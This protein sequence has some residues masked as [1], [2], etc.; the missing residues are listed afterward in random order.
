[1]DITTDLFFCPQTDKASLRAL[2]Q[3]M[4]DTDAKG[5]MILACSDESWTPAHI[6]PIL[7]DFP[8]LPIFG[9]VFPYI[10]Y[11]GKHYSSG[12][13]VVGLNVL[14]HITVIRHIS[15]TTNTTKKQINL[16]GKSI[17]QAKSLIT[18]VDGLAENIESFLEELCTFIAKG[19]KVAGGGAGFL[20]MSKRPCVFTNAGMLADAA[21][22]V[23][24]DAPIQLAAGH[25][26][27]IMKGPFLVT[28]SKGNVLASLNYAS[29]FSVYQEQVEANS[30]TRC[31]AAGFASMAMAYPLGIEN[32]DG[33]ILVRDPIHLRDDE[34]VCIGKIHEN[35]VVYLL[36]G[37]PQ[38]LVAAAGETARSLNVTQQQTHDSVMLFDCISRALF[39]GDDFHKELENIGNNL[40]RKDAFFGAL[41]IGEICSSPNGQVSFL[42]KSTVL[43]AF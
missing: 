11:R 33:E 14:P 5:V 15:A 12:M 43:A 30:G 19:V 16:L 13:L 8:H 34:L 35:S 21:V 41:T 38:T 28:E 23:A 27:E 3:R 4:S 40:S 1:M 32:L 18:F 29:A 10:V 17:K 2:L 7:Q 42:N 6:D 22:L 24:L 36:K 26:W 20:D 25:G 39:L 37:D 31:G 9:G